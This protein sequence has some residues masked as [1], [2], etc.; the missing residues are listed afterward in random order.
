[1][2][3]FYALLPGLAL[4][5]TVFAADKV[6][7]TPHQV[8]YVT[9][10]K[11]AEVKS[12]VELAIT[13]QGLVINNIATVGDMLERTGKDLGATRQVYTQGDVL[14]FCSAG[15]SREM[16][17]ADQT[18]IAFCPYTIQ[19]YAIP[20]QPG[21]VFVGYRRVPMIGND[22]SKAALEKINVLLEKIVSEA[23]SW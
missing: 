13:D 18:N 19:V 10:G 20:E 4:S 21:K 22:A 2:N 23:L 12:N 14:E 7:D 1:M 3:K 11:F 15:L 17:E 6:Q 16:A 5:I 8:L 9:D